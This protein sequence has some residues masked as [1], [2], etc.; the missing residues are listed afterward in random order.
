MRINKYIATAGIAS[1]RKADDLIANGN[2]KVNGETV[3]ELGYDVT[4]SDTVSVNGRVVK[5]EKRMVYIALNKPVGYVTTVSDDKKRPKVMDLVTDADVRLFPVGRLDFNTSGLLVLTNDGDLANKMTHPKHDIYK[6][7]RALVK[8]IVSDKQLYKLT[9]GVDIGGYVT[10]PA[11]VSV[12]KII[13]KN[14]LIELSIAE[15]KNRQIRKMLKAVDRPVIELTRISIGEIKLGRLM[16]GGYRKLKQEE[17]EY[18]KN[19]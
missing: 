3:A 5:P 18:L 2:V 14:T 13:G 1:R 19:I 8:G 11:K 9:K 12:V 7:Y 10:K 16:V 4:D 17:I 15:G 6:T